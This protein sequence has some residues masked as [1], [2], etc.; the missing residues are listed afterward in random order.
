MDKNNNNNNKQQNL[1]E[2][3]QNLQSVSGGGDAASLPLLPE[4]Q[5]YDCQV[6]CNTSNS[7]KSW[8]NWDKGSD[9]ILIILI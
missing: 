3:D 2:G 5:A 7:W 1:D 8:W 9:I 4:I 6:N